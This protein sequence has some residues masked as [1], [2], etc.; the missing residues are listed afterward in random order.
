MTNKNDRVNLSKEEII[1]IK[2]FEY[3]RYTDILK[4]LKIKYQLK[5]KSIT[6][7]ISWQ[8]LNA[9][10]DYVTGDT[11]YPG[12]IDNRTLWHLIFSK[13]EVKRKRD[14]YVIDAKIWEFLHGIYGGGPILHK[15]KNEVNSETVSMRSSITSFEGTSAGI[16]IT[17]TVSQSD[18]GVIG[19]DNNL[20]GRFGQDKDMSWNQNNSK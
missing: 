13:T 6:Y 2:E 18:L 5:K 17:E 19:R 7:L 10:I 1:K 8:W 4:D 16:V 12:P 15:E 14:Y 3:R 20:A 9:W 11:P